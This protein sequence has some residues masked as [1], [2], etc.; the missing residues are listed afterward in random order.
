LG[1]AGVS[2][3]RMPKRSVPFKIGSVTLTIWAK[4]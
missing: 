2:I 3:Q 1:K 4:L